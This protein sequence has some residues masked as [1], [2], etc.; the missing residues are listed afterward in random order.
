MSDPP[1][2]CLASELLRSAACLM[3]RP[4]LPQS[5]AWSAPANS[6]SVRRCSLNILTFEFKLHYLLTQLRVEGTISKGMGS[7]VGEP[8]GI[9]APLDLS[10]LKTCT[11]AS[12]SEMAN[13]RLSSR[14]KKSSPINGMAFPVSRRTLCSASICKTRIWWRTWLS[15]ERCVPQFRPTTQGALNSTAQAISCS[16]TMSLSVDRP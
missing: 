1:R 7:A 15:Q 16:L 13:T 4:T 10:K 2:S 5:V 14:L 6:S 11:C 9:S 12:P 8:L 3:L